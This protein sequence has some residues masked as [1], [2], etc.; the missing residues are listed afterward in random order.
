[1]RRSL[2]TGASLAGVAV[3]GAE[4]GAFNSVLTAPAAMRRQLVRGGTLQL[5]VQAQ[6]TAIEPF[7]SAD[8]GVSVT[9]QQVLEPLV[10]ANADLIP[11]PL[12]AESWAASNGNKTWTF[13]LR[14][15]VQYNNGQPFGADDVVS[16]FN[17]ILAPN[18]TSS[19][20]GDLQGVLSAGGT[21][22]VDDYTV[23]FHLDA[24]CGTFPLRI[25]N[26]TLECGIPPRD[27]KIGTFV[28]NPV[29]TGP[30]L[31]SSFVPERSITFKKNP[32][33][34]QPGVPYLDGIVVTLQSELSAQVLELEAGSIDVMLQTPL[35][36]SEALLHNPNI[37]FT[38]VKSAGYRSVS[39]RTDKKPFDD[40]RVRLALALTLDRKALVEGLLLGRGDLGNDHPF[41]PV[42]GIDVGIPQRTQ[43]YAKAKQL[44]SDAGYASG[45]SVVVTAQNDQE[46]PQYVTVLQQQAK[47]AG[48]S[49]SLNILEGN[50]F[51]GSAGQAQPW[52]DDVL[53]VAPWNPRVTPGEL[54]NPAFLSDS[55]FNQARW[56][57]P[58]FD[59]AMDEV[60]AQITVVE[61]TPPA[62]VAANI[63]H[64]EV[65]AIIGYWVQLPRAFAKTVQGLPLTSTEH[66]DCRR[67]YIS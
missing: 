15:G 7:N 44:L 12:L 6:T 47:P 59:R 39:M 42:Y 20:K 17:R 52:L 46:I 30:F 33:Y 14:K 49:L 25:S 22:K 67:V 19:S 41:A 32:S 18:S 29:G 16:W 51:Y 23:V 21:K 40:V 3:L 54:V 35:Q 31:L 1:M 36:G 28:Q 38:Y 63:F 37:D 60:D 56:H 24:A 53:V 34:W 43:D 8:D 48:F 45:L 5:G 13:K 64:N 57:V 66:I 50:A 55:A 62:K 9:L 11:R 58:A 2:W 27:Y 10:Y 26:Y 4:G 65:P 61:Q